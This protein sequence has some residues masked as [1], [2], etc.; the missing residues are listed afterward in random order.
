MAK[1][2][3]S[4]DVLSRGRFTLGV[5]IGW[6]SEEF[7]ALGVPWAGRARRT[8]E[9]VEVLRTLWRDDPATFHGEF[10]DFHDVRSFPK[11]V[12]GGRLPVVL[13]GNSDP[14]LDRVAAYGDGW[15]GFSLT[16]AE[17]PERVAAL[18]ARCEAA[19]RDP[20]SVH[21]AVAV[22]DGGPEALDGL[23]AAGVD[24]VVVVESPPD[25]PS[26]AADWVVGLAAAWWVTP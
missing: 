24:E 7:A 20:G 22:Q 13:G 15:Y 6:S 12:A 1:Q 17:V 11:P 10:V 21:L 26:E 8:G 2:A 19:G 9:Y 16:T 14:A 18:R 5:G 3:A 4:L 25:D 23:E